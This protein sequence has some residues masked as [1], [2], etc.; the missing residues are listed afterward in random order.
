MNNSEYSSLLA[1]MRSLDETVVQEDNKSP[2]G[3]PEIQATTISA[4]NAIALK[5]GLAKFRWCNKYKVQD[6]K[7][8]VMPTG[9]GGKS[10]ETPWSQAGGVDLGRVQK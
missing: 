7:G 3:I 8:K 4:A 2:D 9:Q 1:R 5:K 10:A 6:A